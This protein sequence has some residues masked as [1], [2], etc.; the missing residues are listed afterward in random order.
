MADSLLREVDEA[1][2][3]DRA[4]NWWST[5]RTR[6]IMVAVALVVGTAVNSGW[7]HYREVQGGKVLTQFLENQKLMDSDKAAVAAEGF[8]AIAHAHRGE[9][10]DLAQVWQARALVVAGKKD[11]AI[12]V[13]QSVSAGKSLWSDIACLRLA[14]LD[15]TQAMCLS[16]VHVSPLLGERAEW[17]AAQA[18]S[19]GERDAA[20]ASLEKQSVDAATSQE[21][22]ARLTH[23]V[24]SASR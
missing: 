1:L 4:M 24:A 16:A 22:R 8:A 5:H 6:I 3:A 9:L 17:A 10:R 21:T 23:S 15:A 19:N 14:G 20:I 12:R 18:W 7:Q 2:R 13:L 11:D